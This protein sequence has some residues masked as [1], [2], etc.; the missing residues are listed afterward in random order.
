MSCP[1]LGITSSWTTIICARISLFA[2][3][4][5]LAQDSTKKARKRIKEAENSFMGGRDWL[6]NFK[7]KKETG[8]FS[9]ANVN[10]SP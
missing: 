9:K 3:I 8:H 7:F 6:T 10:L 5:G 4:N 2:S 1:I